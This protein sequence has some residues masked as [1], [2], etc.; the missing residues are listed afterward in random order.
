M[1]KHTEAIIVG[2]IFIFIL[3][4]YHFIYVPQLISQAKQE[5]LHI[6]E[7]KIKDLTNNI[8]QLELEIETLRNDVESIGK[9]SSSNKTTTKVESK[10]LDD[11]IR[12]ANGGTLASD[13]KYK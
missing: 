4:C 9:D 5:Q 10:T 8:S 13:K 7:K 2:I 12:D 6:D 11:I 3:G 1:E